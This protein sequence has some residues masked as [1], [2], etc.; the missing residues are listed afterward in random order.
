VS[1]EK[2]KG[3]IIKSQ[4]EDQIIF[5]YQ[6]KE[7]PLVIA[8]V[9]SR[10]VSEQLHEATDFQISPLAAE[11]AGIAKLQREA[12][13]D[14]IEQEALQKLKDVQEKA[15]KEAYDLGLI[16]G[17]EKAFEEQ[18]ATI[19][20]QLMKLES[21]LELLENLKSKVLSDHETHIMRVIFEIASR[22]AMHEIS[23]KPESIIDVVRQIL[24]ETQSDESLILR[25]AAQDQ[26]FLDEAK[27]RL[28]KENQAFKRVRLE[29]TDNVEPGG[30]ILETNYGSIDASIKTRVQ[31][32]WQTIA[33][34]LPKA[35]QRSNPVSED[36]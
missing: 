18:G 19:K 36:K 31:R 24:V 10:F 7:F 11:Q 9:A 4:E 23:I 30:C 32:A 16:E 15:Y 33:D 6:P 29:P 28:I 20:A 3:K 8:P 5:S 26:K 25:I 14:R 21:F 35:D 1:A 27:Q 17:R 12:L 13:N 22:I 2:I 34:R